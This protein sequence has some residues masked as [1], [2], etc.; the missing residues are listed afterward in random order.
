MTHRRGKGRSREQQV[1]DAAARAI[2]E[3]GLAQVRVSDVA[4]R[5]GMT[6]GHVTYY[7]P[8]KDDLLMQA[9]RRSE[10]S[11]TAEVAAE[12]AELAD[13]WQRL[14][15]L[16][17]LSAAQS[18]GDPGW[19]LWL[20]VWSR[21]AGDPAVAQVHDELD[22][23]WRAIL[24]DVIEYGRRRGDFVTDDPQAAALQLSALVDGLSIQLALG[25]TGSSAQ[26]LL[27]LARAAA[28]R[29]LG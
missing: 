18:V 29:L 5:A 3:L 11:L 24:V 12:L 1:L 23:A 25:A 6:A 7:F 8:S 13:P 4:E 28:E 14:D 17:A 2:T 9:L 16:L 19:V 26:R 10:A 15:R 21:A 20:H 27:Q 22:G